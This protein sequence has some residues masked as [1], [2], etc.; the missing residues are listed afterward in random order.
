MLWIWELLLRMAVADGIRSRQC[1]CCIFACGPVVPFLVAFIRSVGLLLR[2]GHTGVPLQVGGH[3]PGGSRYRAEA[4]M[5]VPGVLY[6]I[7]SV[8]H[9]RAGSDRGHCDESWVSHW[10][11]AVVCRPPEVQ[12]QIFA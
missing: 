12:T 9:I 1:R 6:V 11:I 4:A 10:S 2:A 7:R 3:R 8:R 5:H